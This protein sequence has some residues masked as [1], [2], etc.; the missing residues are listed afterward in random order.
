MDLSN[1]VPSRRIRGV[2]QTAE[3][4][5]DATQAHARASLSPSQLPGDV[6]SLPA[7]SAGVLHGSIVLG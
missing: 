6:G 2:L 7:G 1:L 5:W 4:S 3:R